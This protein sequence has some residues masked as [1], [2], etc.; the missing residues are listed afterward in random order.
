MEKKELV[1]KTDKKLLSIERESQKL[2]KNLKAM[3]QKT[4]RQRYLTTLGLITL[5]ALLNKI[6]CLLYSANCYCDEFNSQIEK[7]TL[8]C[9]PKNK[10]ENRKTTPSSPSVN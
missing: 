9:Y 6:K 1:E 8:K 2:Q 7:K 4:F 10:N 5:L 3:S